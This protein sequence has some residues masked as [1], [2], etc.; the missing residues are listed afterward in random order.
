MFNRVGL[1]LE[2]AARKRKF[3][4]IVQGGFDVMRFGFAAGLIFF[5]G[6]PSAETALSGFVMSGILIV[7]AHGI[8]LYRLFKKDGDGN[9][10]SPEKK[11][12][13]NTDLMQAFQTPLILSHACIW[14]T[15]MSER[16]VLNYFGSPGDVGGYAAVYQLAFAP[17]LFVS[18]FLMI[19]FEPIIYQMN[20]L[21]MKNAESLQAIQMNKYAAVGILCFSI[22]LFAVLFLFHQRIGQYFLG[23][24]FHSY[25]W[26]FPWL[27]LAGGCFAATQQLLLKL[28][29]EMR[30]DLLA[31]LWLVV[32]VTA[33]IAYVI[34][35]HFWQL[36]GIVAAVTIVNV[37]LVLFLLVFLEKNF[38]Q[39]RILE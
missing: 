9:S 8:F 21:N 30:T 19:F 6:L 23:V 35:A 13:M 15:M 34:G 1:A 4:G 31:V 16:W 37:M 22:C 2:D 3:R 5:L 12:T 27:M 18:N 38:S 32:A 33:M 26:I 28:S 20:R 11:T 10:V 36:K 25:T 7:L 17:M 39:E 24:R 29:S 14:L